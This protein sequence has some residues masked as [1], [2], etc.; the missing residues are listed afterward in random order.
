MSHIDKMS[1]PTRMASGGGAPL[2]AKISLFSCC[3]RKNWSNSRLAPLL[4]ASAPPPEN[5]GSTTDGVQNCIFKLA[6]YRPHPKD[7]EGN[8]FSLFTPGGV[9]ISHNALQHFRECH[10]AARGRDTLPGPAGGV[11]C[12]VQPGGYPA[13]G[14]T[15][16]GV[17]CQGGTLWGYPGG[18]YPGGG[19]P[20][21]ETPQPGRGG[22][23]VRTTEGVFTTRRAVCLLRS[24]RRTF[25]FH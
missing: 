20:G 13:G 18:G 3:V 17:P 22:Y 19:Y 2:W 1:S 14:G 5:A 23:P 25:L 6:N 16:L 15:L 12:Q 10:G 8:V 4:G 7:G 11:P 24:R 21:R 9:P